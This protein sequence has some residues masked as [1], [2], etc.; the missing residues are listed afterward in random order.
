MHFRNSFQIVPMEHHFRFHNIQHDV[1]VWFIPRLFMH[2]SS[3]D[4]SVA[5]DINI[6]HCW[7]S[8]AISI[9]SESAP[10]PRRVAIA[11]ATLI[12]FELEKIK[13]RERIK[14]QCDTDTGLQSAIGKIYLMSSMWCVSRLWSYMSNV[15]NHKQERVRLLI[16]DILASRNRVET[17]SDNDYSICVFRK[18][19]VYAL[20]MFTFTRF[21]F[22]SVPCPLSTLTFFHASRKSHHDW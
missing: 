5:F 1:W 3:S 9:S 15:G 21:R 17:I 8:H 11:G 4:L 19:C 10:I 6:P 13:R 14:Q 20:T 7:P 12:S 22:S 18:S 16:G 2:I